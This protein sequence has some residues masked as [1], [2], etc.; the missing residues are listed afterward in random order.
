MR[1]K[2]YRRTRSRE[3]LNTVFL[4]SWVI[5]NFRAEVQKPI[6]REGVFLGYKEL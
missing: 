4:C 5:K 1:F 3:I 2:P 6:K